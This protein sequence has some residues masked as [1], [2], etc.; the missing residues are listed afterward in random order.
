M[1]KGIRSCLP[2][3]SIIFLGLGGQLSRLVGDTTM[4]SDAPSLYTFS[5][6]STSEFTVGRFASADIG[7]FWLIKEQ[8]SSLAPCRVLGRVGL[9]LNLEVEPC[10]KTAVLS[11]FFRETFR[12]ESVDVPGSNAAPSQQTPRAFLSANASFATKP[13]GRRRFF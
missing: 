12:A 10:L 7:S 11:N 2:G 6:T 13:T 1:N 5:F 4:C 3:S 9:A 8:Y